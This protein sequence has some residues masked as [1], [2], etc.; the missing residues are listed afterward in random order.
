MNVDVY[1]GT[2]LV[3]FI[4][5]FITRYGTLAQVLLSRDDDDESGIAS[6]KINDTIHDAL[7]KTE[8]LDNVIRVASWNV[9]DDPQQ[10]TWEQSKEN[11]CEGI[12]KI[13]P[14]AFGLQEVRKDQIAYIQKCLPY[15]KTI[16]EPS[17]DNSDSLYTPIFYR[18][19]LRQFRH[20]RSGTFWLSKTMFAKI[21]GSKME[22]ASRPRIC[23]WSHMRFATR[24]TRYPLPRSSHVYRNFM[25]LRQVIG[26]PKRRK[27]RR[28]RTKW[29]WRDLI[30]AN[31]DLDSKDPETAKNQLQFLFDYL[32]HKEIGPR[33]YPIILTGDLKWEGSQDVFDTVKQNGGLN[34]AMESSRVT[35][36]GPFSQDTAA[37]ANPIDYIYHKKLT[38]VLAATVNDDKKVEHSPVF[39]AF[40]F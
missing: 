28:R 9:Y 37:D 17:S 5:L 35:Y 29:R 25:W 33:D 23:T 15:Y 19:D 31:T 1:M 24:L 10:G 27:Q 38:G 16:A 14:I 12:K 30:I 26:L 22:K 40:I 32:Y 8:F 21:P 11:V 7:S 13:M 6:S 3:T 34:N 20:V 18:K 39:S 2:L 4:L 36:P